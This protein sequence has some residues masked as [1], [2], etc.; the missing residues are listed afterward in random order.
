MSRSTP[1]RRGVS[2]LAALLAL[3]ALVGACSRREAPAPAARPA[4][5]S[6]PAASFHGGPAAHPNDWCGSHGV[7]ESECTRCNPELIAQFQARHDWCG[8]HSV[9]ESQCA[10]CHPELLRQG[11]AP[12]RPRSAPLEPGEHG[13][14]TP[15]SDA[16]AGLAPGTTV[17]LA[18]PAV[19]AQVGVETVTAT[20]RPLVD[21][22]AVPARL[23]FDPTR[24]ARV[25]ARVPGVVR[26]MAVG[27]G[28]VVR[29]GDLL[30]TLDSAAAA[31][32][33]ADLDAARTRTRLTETALQRSRTLQAE[34]IDSR[35]SVEH[36][37]AEHAA[38]RAS[39]AG[40]V[41]AGTALSGSGRTVRVLSPRAGV[42]VAR[43]A[44][45]GQQVTAEEVLV[46]VADLSRMWAILDVPDAQAPRLSV[47]QSV[48][49]E[50]DGFAAPLVGTIAFLAP[51]VDPH[52]RTVEARVELANPD[53]RLRANTFGRARVTVAA[54]SEGVVLP[55]DALQR[56]EAQDVVFVERSPAVYEARVVTIA[57]R[58]TDDV[59]LRE[60]VVP[61]DRVVTTGGF[62][63]KT[64]I[65]R[66]SIGAGCCPDEG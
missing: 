5:P 48:A 32:T 51:M 47:G 55:R 1:V 17:R 15:R 19:A 30:L 33:R 10:A 66:D 46:E 50:L 41:A 21:E 20:T 36:A 58:T 38:A 54:A 23:A 62:Q 65:L 25:S 61:G 44:A 43:A 29:P 26:A 12:P 18:S 24:L 39:L 4:T 37:E 28:A 31:A 8:E 14:R 3:A 11:V 56:V 6:A 64:E 52:T 7:P 16:S 35:A 2:I 57:R 59:L 13:D 27:V 53:G 45:V 49:I 40:Y 60:G 9:P 63:L 22:V 34:G 42:V